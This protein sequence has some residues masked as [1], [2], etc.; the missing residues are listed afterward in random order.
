MEMLMAHRSKQQ[1]IFRSGGY[2][3]SASMR[4]TRLSSGLIAVIAVVLSISS[5]VFGQ[6]V[7][8]PLKLD[9]LKLQTGKSI[10]KPL[11]VEN[12]TSQLIDQVDL[13]IVDVVQD[14]NGT[15]TPVQPQD[16][17][18]DWTTIRSCAKWMTLDKA[19][20]RLPPYQKGTF[21][22]TVTAPPRVQGHYYAAITAKAILPAG[23]V[24]GY[25]T[26][27]GMEYIIP[28]LIEIQSRP[29]RNEV[30]LAGVG[31]EFRP[32]TSS[33]DPAAT[34][35]TLGVT[36]KGGTFCRLQGYIRVS[37]WWGGHWRRITESQ[38]SDIGILPGN[39][40]LLK[41]DVGRALP[42]GT[43]KIEGFL[44][45][46]GIRTDQIQNGEFQFDGDPRTPP[47]NHGESALD[48]DPRELKL[49]AVPNSWKSGKI[50]I[51]NATDESVTVNVDVTLP[52]HLNALVQTDP[53]TGRKITSEEYGCNKWTTVEPS[54]FQL[55]PYGRQSL[56]VK[57][58]I[59][60][61]AT[62]LPNYYAD[63]S[64]RT[65]FPDGQPA[66][67]AKGRVCVVMKKTPGAPLLTV[68]GAV[69]LSEL[70]PTKFL[71]FARTTN[72]G[73]RHALPNC[74]VAVLTPTSEI[75][76]RIAMSS[77][78]YEQGGI[79]LPLEPRNFSGVLD[80]AGLKAGQYVL[81]V[82]LETEGYSAQQS[83]TGLII[84]ESGGVKTAES[85]GVDAVGGKIKAKF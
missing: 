34:M 68:A 4:D 3:G 56:F 29:M 53:N 41:R 5:S 67:I 15:W 23:S 61:T 20:L 65:Q 83:Q 70:S 64:L 74:Y 45:V 69:S 59:P 1:A 55:G 47:V 24:E 31:L 2:P 28:I 12:M 48:F 16:P 62:G 33:G 17:N 80:I 13:S 71:L 36:N 22:L 18:V 7:I 32:Q 26:A 72:M 57:V 79:Q 51:V 54:Q 19:S 42:K 81:G 44:V 49:D 52:Q 84:K 25:K 37:N 66:G 43:Y 11:Y 30:E 14:A 8:S 21:T 38:F 40:L 58:N 85:V 60:E 46:N 6:F 82:S 75:V 39:K 10:H 76:Q 63:L 77:E 27:V 9:D 50:Q 73:T 35:A 78:M